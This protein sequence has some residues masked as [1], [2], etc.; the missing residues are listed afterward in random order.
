MNKNYNMSL[1]A[2]TMKN[3]R[4]VNTG[5]PSWMI[6]LLPVWLAVFSACSE[7]EDIQLRE[8]V[9]TPID[10]YTSIDEASG[11]IHIQDLPGSVGNTYSSGH[12]PVFFDLENHAIINPYDEKGILLELPDEGKKS[13]DWDVA[14]TSIYNSYVTINNG[15]IEDSPAHGG[16]GQ[17]AMIVIDAL[18]D[19]V[20]EAPSDEEFAAFMAEQSAAGWEDFPPGY[21]GWY[22]YS[23]E[24][25]VM[26]AITGVTI[27]IRTP[28]NRYA[29]MEMHS[30][31][32]DSPDNPTVNTPAPYFSFRYYLQKDGSRNLATQ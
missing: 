25:H 11:V 26:S 22:F 18:F 23:L 4:P 13:G 27:V 5:R 24:S 16:Q 15:D 14:F 8:V 10:D 9:L 12:V 30:L 31:Y 17:G 3:S 6:L 7:E 19:E 28:D 21:K 20:N 32:L 29:K 2:K 1:K